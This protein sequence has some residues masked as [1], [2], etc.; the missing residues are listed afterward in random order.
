MASTG[1]TGYFEI[2]NSNIFVPFTTA[3]NYDMVIRTD[4]K[5]Q[6]IFVGTGSNN[7]PTL[8]LSSNVMGINTVGPICTL[9]VASN[10]LLGSN[11]VLL[12]LQNTT[13]G[14]STGTSLDFVTSNT[15]F[16]QAR[17]Q[18]QES[19]FSGHIMFHTKV[20]GS[21]SNSLIERLRLTPEGRMGLNTATPGYDFEVAGTIY[22]SSY[23]LAMSD[24]RYKT[25]LVGLSN[26]VDNISKL[27]GYSYLRSDEVDKKRHIGLIAQEVDS[28]YP[29]LVIHDSVNDK[30]A[31]NYGS[32]AALFV[33]SIKELK[34]EILEL[35]QEI[36]EL[37]SS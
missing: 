33:E 32:M 2:I 9:H 14:L 36:A 20:P 1:Q 10:S 17:V 25:D 18:V 30:F 16:P 23:I 15:T 11:A 31:I 28:V 27:N 35:R 24:K 37:K 26:C 12:T 22:A 34:Q 5:S 19:N 6:R 7:L 4:Q 13:G 29:E 21:D 8:L 3:S